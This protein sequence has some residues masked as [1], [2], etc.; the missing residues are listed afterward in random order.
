MVNMG[1]PHVVGLR[2]RVQYSG[3]VRFD[4]DSLPIERDFDLFRLRV[5]DEAATVEMKA[6]LA[7]DEAR[8]VVEAFLRPWEIFESVQPASTGL[9]FLFEESEVIDRDPP[10]FYVEVSLLPTIQ[11]DVRIVRELPFPELPKE[12]AVSPDV[13]VMWSLYE[14]YV[15]GHDRLLPMAYTCLT[16]LTYSVG[17]DRQEAAEKYRI[18]RKVLTRLSALSTSGDEATARKW[19]PSRSPQAL[20]DEEIDWVESAV[21][22]L[23]LR[24]GQYAADPAQEWPQ[25]TMAHLPEL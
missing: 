20:T 12:F 25:I 22:M 8:E 21:K 10:P 11:A 14:A 3:G 9:R 1:D 4:E 19:V 13:E 23:I 5:T 16:R 6:H 7:E 18:S 24:A 15:R 17:G 2:Y